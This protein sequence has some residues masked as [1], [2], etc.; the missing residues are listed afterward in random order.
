M[1]DPLSEHQY[2]ERD[3]ERIPMHGRPA[4]SG[5]HNLLHVRDGTFSDGTSFLMAVEY[6][7]A[8]CPTAYAPVAPRDPRGYSRKIWR[9]GVLCDR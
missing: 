5:V 9:P 7:D 6:T 2:L 1:D 8:E 3:G 4:T